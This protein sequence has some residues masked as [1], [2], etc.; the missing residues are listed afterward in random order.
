MGP[1]P[2]NKCSG[3]TACGWH[4]TFRLLLCT[5]CVLKF[6]YVWFYVELWDGR[7]PYGL[8]EP[9]LDCSLPSTSDFPDTPI[10]WPHYSTSLVSILS[11][12]F[13]FSHQHS[14]NIP[15]EESERM[16][17]EKDEKACSAILP[18]GC[19]IAIKTIAIM[20]PQQS[21]FSSQD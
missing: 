10:F 13:A 1:P 16:W 17:E 6:L 19:D 20:N 2:G 21:W 5:M 18:L 4:F 14:G 7:L 3:T 11:R 15:E 12:T 9:R 8:S